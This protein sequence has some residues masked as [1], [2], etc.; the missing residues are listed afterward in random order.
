MA[1]KIKIPS[2]LFA[3]DCSR[4]GNHFALG[5]NDGSLIIKS[6]QLEKIEDKDEEEKLLS[7]EPVYKATSKNYR[8][9]YRG[10]YIQPEKEDLIASY[11]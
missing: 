7:F 4:D 10:Q 8:Y 3:L 5:L 2:E 6:K 11:K 9:F 1:Y